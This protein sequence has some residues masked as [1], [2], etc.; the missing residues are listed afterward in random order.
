MRMITEKEL[1][2]L[3]EKIETAINELSLENTVDMPDWI[4][5]DYLAEQ[6]ESFNSLVVKNKAWHQKELGD[7]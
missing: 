6:F 7:K 2:R 4:I 3:S 5:A 1:S